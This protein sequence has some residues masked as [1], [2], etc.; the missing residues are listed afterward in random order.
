LLGTPVTADR[1]D[2]HAYDPHDI[3]AWIAIDRDD[4]VLIR[5]QRSEMG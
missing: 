3:D 2:D 1:N 5:Y 4:C